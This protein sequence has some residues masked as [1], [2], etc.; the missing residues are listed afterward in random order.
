VSTI[1]ATEAEG[2]GEGVLHIASSK[3]LEGVNIVEGNVIANLEKEVGIEL[4]PIE[5]AQK[6]SITISAKDVRS[7]LK[8]MGYD[9]P[10]SIYSKEQLNSTLK[11]TPRL[12]EKE[13]QTFVNKA[14]K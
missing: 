1:F 6:T 5:F 9:L 14:N 11:N 3:D 2:Y 12:T 7:I 13:I 10:G 8:D 4:T